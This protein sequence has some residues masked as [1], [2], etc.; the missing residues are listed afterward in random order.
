MKKG[1]LI[2]TLA[3]AASFLAGCNDNPNSG[4]T[5][6]EKEE[7]NGLKMMYAFEQQSA[8]IDWEEK[9]VDQKYTEYYYYDRGNSTDN[10]VTLFNPDLFEEASAK[11]MKKTIKKVEDDSNDYE[12]NGDH[13]QFMGDLSESEFFEKTRFLSTGGVGARHLHVNL[14]ENLDY[15]YFEMDEGFKTL[16]QTVDY[17]IY[18]NDFMVE[19]INMKRL[20]AT[21]ETYENHT[22]VE[23]TAT[24]RMTNEKING[25]T[26]L[27]EIM[28]DDAAV[29]GEDGK[30]PIPDNYRSML[31]NTRNMQIKDMFSFPMNSGLSAVF[32]ETRY[33][34][35]SQ[36]DKTV[37][38]LSSERDASGNVTLKYNHDV[39]FDSGD[40]AGQGVV[41]YIYVTLTADNKI[42]N[43][44]Y[45][46]DFTYYG[47]SLQSYEMK[48]EY[49]YDA[50]G[51]YVKAEGEDEIFDYNKYYD[52]GTLVPNVEKGNRDSEA[53][54]LL[55]SIGDCLIGETINEPTGTVE[56]E[57]HRENIETANG[58]SVT[59]ES[60]MQKDATLYNDNVLVKYFSEQGVDEDDVYYAESGTIQSFNKDDNNYTITQYNGSSRFDNGKVT[61]SGNKHISLF[62]DSIIKSMQN[63]LKE[64]KKAG[65][66]ITVALTAEYVEAGIDQDTNEFM[67][68]HYVIILEVATQQ[69]EDG[70][71]A[72]VLYTYEIAFKLI[73]K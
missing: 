37:E 11:A 17:K 33:N 73:N 58:S 47:E 21:D 69:S 45:N 34:D 57:Y 38:W 18:D 14:K 52:L 70:S 24:D 27:I 46:F 61:A 35:P 8:Q 26:Y 2:L 62:D 39:Y 59:V 1:T 22:E 71:E 10:N 12:S 3:M 29:L 41:E 55:E 28:H 9:S 13:K 43:Y 48:Y 31:E 6:T 40:Y 7:V 63:W 66:G 65:S 16:D 54:S 23:T 64:S 4:T 50:L 25:S 56:E 53:E 68:A 15:V 67:D 36:M 32:D 19:K 44:G 5:L 20:V 30:Y 60:I 42:D 72:G 49:G 51:D